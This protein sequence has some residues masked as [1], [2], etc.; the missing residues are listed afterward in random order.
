MNTRFIFER[1]TVLNI[2]YIST[3]NTHHMQGLDVY[4]NSVIPGDIFRPLNGH[5]KA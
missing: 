1:I 5:V 2:K 3:V 4:Y